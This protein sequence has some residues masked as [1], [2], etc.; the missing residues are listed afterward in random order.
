MTI[1]EAH[2]VGEDFSGRKL[3]QLTVVSS[4][5]I[6]CRFE[7]VKASQVCFGA[8]GS[9]SNYEECVF[10]RM[11]FGAPAPGNARFVRCSFRDVRVRQFIGRFAEF[12]ECTFSGLIENAVFDGRIPKEDQAVVHREWNEFRGN[13]FRNSDLV[14]VAFRGAIN[15]DDQLLPS[16]PSYFYF[17]NAVRTL[18][19][20]R[21]VVLNMKDLEKRRRA[22]AVLTVLDR[23]VEGGQRQLL[24][25]PDS[26]PGEVRDV[27]VALCEELRD[28]TGS[29]GGA[30]VVTDR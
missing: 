29:A 6:R 5:L 10:D 25:R 12:V 1:E 17:S 19:R 30:G 13:D 2:L 18:K 14:N 9:L 23:A 16:G 3:S 22:M 28:D 8:G 27:A 20:A 15:L 26:M 4:Q 24:L 11:E 21:E 7:E